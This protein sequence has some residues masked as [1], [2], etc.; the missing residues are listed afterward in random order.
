[1]AQANCVSWGGQLAIIDTEQ[2]SNL[3]VLLKDTAGDRYAWM[4]L[5]WFQSTLEWQW[6]DGT[7][8]PLD[9]NNKDAWAWG[10]SGGPACQPDDTNKG[11]AKLCVHYW[12]NTWN[13]AG[14]DWAG[15]PGD[16]GHVCSKSAA[17]CASGLVEQSSASFPGATFCCPACQTG[18]NCTEVAAG[19]PEST[20]ATTAV[21]TTPILSESSCTDAVEVVDFAP[22]TFYCDSNG[23]W[24][25]DCS[26]GPCTSCLA[27]PASALDGDAAT[28][29]NPRGSGGTVCSLTLDLGA[30]AAVL[31]VRWTVFGDGAHDRTTL[32]SSTSADGGLSF[33]LHDTAALPTGTRL[34]HTVAFSS[35]ATTRYLKLSATGG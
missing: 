28:F 29:W 26:V 14:C 17:V 2:E 3:A 23:Q 1:M 9:V 22:P 10:C 35:T 13:D 6:T 32:Q 31:G 30:E 18:P 7:V 19:C 11:L 8:Y 21:A 5:T 4:G 34:V 20:A 27:S 15:V 24:I 33:T 25:A 12:D 16:L